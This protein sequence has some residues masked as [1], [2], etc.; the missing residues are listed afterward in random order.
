[1]E[2]RGWEKFAVGA[3]R[4]QKF[5][6][7][8]MQRI[9]FSFAA[10]CLFFSATS[11][12]AQGDREKSLRFGVQLSPSFSTL[13]SSDKLIESAGTNLGLKLGIVGEKFFTSNYAVSTGIGFSFNHGG[14]IQNGFEKGRFWS[15]SDLSSP[16]LDTLGKNAKLHYRL[17]FVEIPVALKLIGGSGTDNPMRYYVEPSLSFSFLTNALGDIK[18]TQNQNTDDEN[19]R[20]DVNG[21]SLAWGLGGGIEYELAEHL[22][23][24]TGLQYQRSFTDITDDSATVQLSS[25]DWRKD[26]S[27]GTMGVLSIK[28]GVFF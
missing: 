19:I 12:Y 15:K 1:L 20:S 7:T 16:A 4:T 28:V 27:K 23:L 24:F 17:S 6:T 26:K 22:T 13:R 9:L 3:R 2:E 14:T 8:I 18:G 11:L 5:K 10:I 21:L 25:G